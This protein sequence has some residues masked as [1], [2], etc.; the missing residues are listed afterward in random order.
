VGGGER[1]IN[2]GGR[3]FHGRRGTAP[4]LILIAIMLTAYLATP[5]HAQPTWSFRVEV[6]PAKLYMGE[7][8]QLYANIT[9]MDCNVRAYHVLE[10]KS[11]SERYVE[12]IVA[13]AREMRSRGLIGNYSL[14]VENMWGSGGEV[15]GDYTLELYDVCGGRSIE[16]TGA[17][18]WFPIRGIGRGMVFWNN[19][20]FT[21]D[22]FDPVAY[23]LNGSHP[24]SSRLLSF[25]VY[26]PEDIPPD[27]LS[28]KPAIDI[29]V[30]FPGWM[31]Y[32]LESYRIE[33]NNA[34]IQPY[35]S[36]NLTVTDHDGLNPVPGARVV[37]R[38]LMHYYDV[39]EYITP[40][41]GTI[42]IYRLQD[43]DYEITVYW[44]ATRYRQDYPRIYYEQHSA[45][46]LA[47]SKTLKTG[48]FN[49]R[50]RALDARGAPLDGA[51]VVLD[52]VERAAKGGEAVFSMVPQA[53]H[54]IQASWRGVKVYEGWIWAGYHPTI[55]PYKPAVSYELTLPV[56]DLIVEAVDTGGN[57][58]PANF[59]VIGPTPEASVNISSGS[60]LLNASQMPAGEYRVRAASTIKPFNKTVYSEAVFRPGE[61]GRLI[62]P[63]HSLTVIVRDAGGRPLK[64]AGIRLGPLNRTA[65]ED[66]SAVFPGV[67][68][69]EYGLEV[70]WLGIPVHSRR[71]MVSAPA[72]VEAN[73]SVYDISLRFI[74]GDGRQAYADYVFTDP[75][76]RGF[77]GE[78]ADGLKLEDIPDG[79]CNITVMDHEAG[80]ILYASRPMTCELAGVRE[81]KLPIADMVI[82]VSWPDGRPVEK[83][84]IIL[85]DAGSGRKFEE[86]T[87]GN[88]RAAL[89]NMIYSSYKIFTY[90]PQTSLQV[91]SSN[92]SFTG[93]EVRIT[94]GEATVSVRVLDAWGKPLRGAEIWVYYEDIP[95]ANGYTDDSGKAEL[96]VLERPSY[97]V[98]ARYETYW[99][100][101]AAGPGGLAEIRLGSPGIPGTE[102]S[103]GGFPLIYVIVV[104]A[105]LIVIALSI[106]RIRRSRGK[107]L[108]GDMLWEGEE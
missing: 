60:G 11:A 84:R 24:K 34:E 28:T 66:G 86:Q 56:A 20:R 106:L 97:R 53:N 92:I 94:L 48:L 45:W 27:Q 16:V 6:L 41:N 37:M 85:L 12:A 30:S 52:S 26:V 22:A 54:S 67:P 75:A 17:G 57:R 5:A 73:V 47:S 72:R 107:A 46:S 4:F 55:H 7:W 10:L 95:L 44:N 8:N 39:R 38:R 98:S 14:A 29:R 78:S 59:T 77:K 61:P 62:M 103:I 51:K 1:L 100:E 91:Y 101:A 2:I 82:T 42:S 36:F 70:R 99:A 49:V 9:N 32:I 71:I 81:L 96:K 18:V 102:I 89:R 31:E 83:A 105:A 74:T 13:R 87:D 3:P 76:G 25:R 104:L 35:R 43:D 64:G 23:I 33:V 88:G 80:R 19:T 68:E 58:L 40:D 90:Y 69:G 65:G 93:Q 50:I 79:L 108:E 15:Y 21:L 63:V